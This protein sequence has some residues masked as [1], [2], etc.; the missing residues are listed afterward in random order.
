MK[1]IDTNVFGKVFA[2]DSISQI[3]EIVDGAAKCS[4]SD[5]IFMWRGQGDIGWPIHSAAYRRLAGSIVNRL[6]DEQDMRDYERTLLSEARHQG[7][8]FEDGR[9]LSDFELLAKLQHHGAATRLI[10]VSRNMLVAL[11]FACNSRPESTGLLFGISAGAL[12]GLEGS[13]GYENGNYN[14]NFPHTKSEDERNDN[15]P[16]VWQPSVVTKRIAAQSAQFIYS[17][18]SHGY[19]GSLI[20]DSAI[21]LSGVVVLA[22]TPDMKRIFLK[23][24]ER[25]FDIRLL[26]LFPDFDGF[27]R[28]NSDS[29]DIFSNNRW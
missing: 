1:F 8:G 29:F 17:N 20:L 7:Y 3:L 26:T 19:M 12:L 18:V 27:C 9:K 21:R 2:P 23:V 24:L 14:E 6:P 13:Y 11:W 28:A 16:I 5:S 22:I 25:T 4:I 15:L 10:D